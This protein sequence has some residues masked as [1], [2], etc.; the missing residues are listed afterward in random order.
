MDLDYQNVGPSPISTHVLG[1]YNIIAG[2]LESLI[3]YNRG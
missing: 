2:L 3:N 1:N